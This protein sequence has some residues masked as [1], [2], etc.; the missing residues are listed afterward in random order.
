MDVQR[1]KSGGSESGDNDKSSSNMPQKS[2][3]NPRNIGVK[4]ALALLLILIV[5]N[6]V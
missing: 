4:H 6:L 2:I 1:E 5:Y 3:A